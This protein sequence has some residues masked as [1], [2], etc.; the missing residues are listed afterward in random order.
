MKVTIHNVCREC[1]NSHAK[2]PY[3]EIYGKLLQKMYDV[4]AYIDAFKG[5]MMRKPFTKP[6]KKYDPLRI[7]VECEMFNKIP[8]KPVKEVS[9]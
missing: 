5:V 7:H 1:I 2:C 6:E 4:D 9:K 8:E 3:Y